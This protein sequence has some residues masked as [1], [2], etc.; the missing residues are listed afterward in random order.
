MDGL[1]GFLQNRLKLRFV[2]PEG[3]ISR[4][5]LLKL[6]IPRYEVVPFI[7]TDLCRGEESCGLCLKR[8]PCV[9]I[10]VE[11]GEVKVDV[12]LCCGCGACVDNCP[13]RAIVYPGFSPEE[14]DSEMAGLLSLRVAQGKP[15]L[16]ALTCQTCL[17]L[18]GVDSKTESG[19]LSGLAGLKIPC[20][21]MAS[22][23]LML[24]AFDRG[25]QGLALVS[26]RQGCSA[27]MDSSKWE[28]NV[29][30]IRGL[31]ECWGIEPERIGIFEVADGTTWELEQFLRK[32]SSLSPTPLSENEPAPLP[33]GGLILPAL[34]EAVV[35][36]LG[37]DSA[38]WVVTDGLVP[39]GKLELDSASCTGCG[40]CAAGCPTGALTFVA[41]EE[42]DYQLLFRHD[43]CIACGRCLEICPEQ[44]FRLE[45]ILELDRMNRPAEVLFEGDVAR[46]RE[47]GNVIGPRAMVER[48]QAKL[49]DARTAYLFE[50]CN[51]CKKKQLTASISTPEKITGKD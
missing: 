46:C 36:K 21:A 26:G 41:D 8:C 3:V 39:F 33:A 23:W 22:P 28:E 10:K 15:E 19:Y 13:H 50:L 47:C 40:L 17:A 45:R 14:L 51:L 44:C 34:I 7:E 38:Q 29:T 35:N 11:D 5:E 6:A 37:G 24:R 20:L 4:R 31:L 18:P 1:K 27:G 25:V 49:M 32:I 2:K 12:E 42:G 48:L 30:F 43:I 9:A 16:I